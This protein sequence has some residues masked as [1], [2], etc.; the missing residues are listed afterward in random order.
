[1]VAWTAW[2]RTSEAAVVGWKEYWEANRDP[3]GHR[4]LDP[5]EVEDAWNSAL[6]VQ[7]TPDFRCTLQ[8]LGDLEGKQVLELGSGHG[9]ETL[10]VALG[11][12]QVLGLDLSE[13][14]CRIARRMCQGKR[15]GTPVSFH[16]GDAS[17]IPAKDRSLDAVFARDILMYAEPARV[18][19]ECFRVLRPGGRVVFNEALGGH[20]LVAL[21]RKGFASRDHQRMV[22]FL[23]DEELQSLGLPDLVRLEVRYFYL[24]SAIAFFA[25]YVLRSA[26]IHRVLLRAFHPID[27]IL[28]DRFPATSRWSWRGV[29]SYLK[30]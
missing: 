3:F 17:E 1:M 14:R 8:L 18:V 4:Q 10:R 13:E 24:F 20:P 21:Y 26:S 12:A 30:E 11:G 25:L 6:D 19:Q 28:S 23:D 29:V 15:A 22:R 16:V 2:S 27:R 5:Q 7:M 9:C